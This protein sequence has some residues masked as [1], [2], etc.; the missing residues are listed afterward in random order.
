MTANLFHQGVP[1]NFSFFVSASLALASILC[2]TAF[3]QSWAPTTGVLFANPATTKVGIGTATPTVSLEVAGAVKIRD[4]LI[5]ANRNLLKEIDELKFVFSILFP[6]RMIFLNGGVFQMGKAGVVD[7]VHQV[8]L[9]SF[10]ISNTECTQREYK[11][12]M[13]ATSN[14]SKFLGE[15][16]PVEC[17]SWFDAV[18]Y[19][20]A[21]SK[22]EGKDTVYTYTSRNGGY[23]TSCL[24]LGGLVINYTKKGYRLP[25]E[26]EWEYACGTRTTSSYF[27]GNDT[28]QLKYYAW[29][30][31][32]SL[33]T[34][35]PVAMLFPNAWGLYDM[36]GNVAEWCNDWWASSYGSA[37]VTNPT[38]P[39][40][41]N[42]K[43]VRGG[44]WADSPA[45]CR[46][47][48]HPCT[49]LWYVGPCFGFRVVLP[50]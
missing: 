22:F 45:G 6:D 31:G 39:G 33:N 19:C 35:H 28:S 27:F 26:A 13:G 34:T 42:N 4:S 21:R 3:A 29:Y 17:V 20:N 14:H 49:N 7:A 40:D 43:V 30:A 8:T 23:A 12:I 16:N 18:L 5:V 11:R 2:S 48:P 47:A 46:T 36:A 41:S 1:L 25:T 10:S 9:S 32:N 24:D 44:Q 37:A 15:T 50:Q 38:G